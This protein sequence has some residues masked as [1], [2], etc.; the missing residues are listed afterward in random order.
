M[1]G[2]LSRAAAGLDQLVADLEQDRKKQRAFALRAYRRILRL[3]K[4]IRELKPTWLRSTLVEFGKTILTVVVTWGAVIITADLAAKNAHRN[5]FAVAAA[6]KQ[7][8]SAVTVKRCMIVA[9]EA[10]RSRFANVMENPNALAAEGLKAKADEL[11]DAVYS[12]LLPI[13]QHQK[14]VLVYKTCIDSLG[15]ISNE[16]DLTKRKALAAAAIKTLQQRWEEADNEM[17]TWLS[18]RNQ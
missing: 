4:S 11:R 5:S 8:E 3:E 2:R 18:E 10:F 15:Q 9:V 16:N 14:I 13:K 6:T 7:V 1:F 17:H 12:S